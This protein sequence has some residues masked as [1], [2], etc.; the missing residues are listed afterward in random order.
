MRL[1]YFPVHWKKADVIIL[2]KPGKNDYTDPSAY[3]PICLLP[4]LGKMLERIILN[5]IISLSDL[6]NWISSS[7]HGF[8][9]GKSTTSALEELTKQI[10]IGS[11]KRCYTSCVLL[12][13]KGAFD[14]EWHPSIITCLKQRNWPN[15]LINW[16]YSFLS[17]RTATL[18]LFG[19]EF[20]TCV[21]KGCP[22]GSS[23]SPFLWNIIADGALR[24]NLRNGVFIQ[25]FADD[26]IISKRGV[27]KSAIQ[28]SLQEASEQLIEWGNENQLSLSGPKTEWIYFHSQTRYVPR[29]YN[30]H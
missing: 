11:Q 26:L 4:I 29:T 9:R 16:I 15:Y 8:R 24:L 19:Q 7:Q 23:L 22:Q 3:R 14:N 21:E 6:S 1:N 30:N 18:R 5:R 2:P 10:N 25:G 28:K 12:D 20:E 13:I 27:N 17:Q